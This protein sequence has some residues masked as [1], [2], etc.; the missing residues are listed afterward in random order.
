MRR[1]IHFS[2]VFFALTGCVNQREQI[3]GDNLIVLEG[4]TIINGTGT[5]PTPNSILILQGGRIL[6]IGTVGDFAYPTDAEVI[7][8]SGKWLVP[9]FID[10]HAHMPE[11]KDQESV[12]RVLL[13]FGITT[14]RAPAADPPSGVELRGR[15]AREEILGPRL[16]TAG[17]LIDAPGGIFSGW[18]AEVTNDEEIRAEVRRQAKAGVDFIKL[19]R[20][21]SLALVRAAI[22]EAHSLNLRVIGHLGA[23]TW[24]EAAT[25][26]IDGLSHF[27]IYATPWELVPESDR[28]TVK[29]A[30]DDCSNIGDEEGFRILRPKVQWSGPEAT[31]WAD[32][33]AESGVTVEPNLVLLRSVLWGDSVGF[34]DQ[35]EPS[36]APPSWRDGTWFDHVPHPYQAPCTREW[37]INAQLT[38]PL[39]EGLVV[40]LHR[41]GVILTVGTD[42]M[43]PWMTPGVSYHR[44]LELL[45]NAGLNASEV[46]VA[47]TRNGAIAVGIENEVGTIEQGKSADL[48]VLN[49]DPLLNIQNTRAIETV[50]FRGVKLDPMKLLQGKYVAE[51]P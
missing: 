40:T 5:A 36:Y 16:K 27:G 19:Y 2:L 23:T 42:L 12:L 4:A 32:H 6:R 21:L 44:E 28:P 37:V 33:L 38:Y 10:T 41:S 22:E 48:V 47:A 31:S 3:V 50:F 18:A 11:P 34:L 17:R 14:V 45:V 51:V 7:H 15:L 46:M 26:G 8:L 9:G 43:N 35:L 1:A 39:F 30:C 25:V 24:A 49:K 13:A 20:G 29:R